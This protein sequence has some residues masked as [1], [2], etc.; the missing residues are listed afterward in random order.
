MTNNRARSAILLMDAIGWLALAGLAVARPAAA[1]PPDP[2]FHVVNRSASVVWYIHVRISGTANWGPDL[3]G[4]DVLV[5]RARFQVTPRRDGNCVFDVRVTYKTGPEDGNLQS[6]ERVRQNLCQ[7]TEMAFSGASSNPDFELVNNSSKSIRE[8]YVSP[9]Q[10]DAWG[11]DRL[12]LILPPGGRHPVRL[13]RDGTCQYDVR[14][15]YMDDSK[16]ERRRQDLCRVT[17]MAF[18][19]SNVGNS[20]PVNAGRTPPSATAF[21]TGFFVS[22]QG[23]ALT[24][25]HVTRG[26]RSIVAVR[27]GRQEPAQLVQQDERNDLALLRIQVPGPVHFA[28]FRASPSIKPGEGVLVA[29]FPLPGVL[30]NGLNV[31][32]GNVSALAGPGGNSALLQVTAAVQPDNSGGPLLDSGASLVGVVV[33]QLDAMRIAEQTGAFP[34][35]VN[36]AIQGAVARLFLEASGVGAV[37]SPAG[38]QLPVG[39]VSDRAREFTFQLECRQ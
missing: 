19:G 6:E 16:E 33:G 31:T 30:Q 21:G 10:S 34:Q 35:N 22:A 2:S 29:G 5:S 4:G 11:E 20:S 1:Q 24:N 7:I 8:L 3:L 26:C 18:T 37:E 38:T 28:R 23:H 25:L 27:E 12:P 32:V 17:E 36:F 39:E 15:V 14:V 13:S 9:V